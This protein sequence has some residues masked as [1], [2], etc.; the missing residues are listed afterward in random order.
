MINLSTLN[1]Y[2][3]TSDASALATE[4]KQGK[5]AINNTGSTGNMTLNGTIVAGK[6]GN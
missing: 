1:P 6:G 4:I 3:R 5:T 2:Y